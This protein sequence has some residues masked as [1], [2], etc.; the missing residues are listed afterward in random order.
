MILYSR[1]RLQR[2]HP[3]G[4]SLKEESILET[5]LPT[6]DEMEAW[7]NSDVECS[8]RLVLDVMHAVRSLKQ[9]CRKVCTSVD[10]LG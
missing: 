6:L 9:T 4:R 3:I 2:H 10:A 5:R 8:L 1:Q 7:E